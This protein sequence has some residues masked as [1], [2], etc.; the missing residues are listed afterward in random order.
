MDFIDNLNNIKSKLLIIPTNKS[1]KAHIM[2]C[3]NINDNLEKISK[4]NKCDFADGWK[5]HV[6]INSNNYMFIYKG[7]N[8]SVEILQNKYI[9]IKEIYKTTFLKY[10]LNLI[11]VIIHLDLN[12]CKF[13]K[14]FT[15]NIL[16][17]CNLMLKTKYYKY[18]PNPTRLRRSCNICFYNQMAN[19][20]INEGWNNRQICDLNN[21]R[22]I[23][24]FNKEKYIV[25]L[26]DGV[27]EN[28][29][30]F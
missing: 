1:I 30:K 28:I 2:K 26:F 23:F 10:V 8:I 21:D 3:R 18:I 12:F 29:L 6:I 24:Q 13:S 5:N 16:K 19:K 27:I 9:I 22:V 14:V 15:K 11:D 17:M 7:Y 25:H 20:V 4:T